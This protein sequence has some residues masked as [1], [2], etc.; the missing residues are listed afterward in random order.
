MSYKPTFEITP[1]LVRLIIE[2]TELRIWIHESVI[3]VPWLPTLQRETAIRLTHSS[4]AIEGNPL[5]L[6][7][8]QMVIE[9]KEIP[10]SQKAKLEVLNQYEA[11]KWVSK[12][13]PNEAITE[14]SLLTLHRIIT[15][16][17]LP[18]ELS[19]HFKT[20]SNRIVDS[21]GRTVYTPPPP[22]KARPMTL[23]LLA[24][25]NSDESRKLHPTISSAI[26]HYQHVSIHPFADGNGRTSRALAIWILYTRGFDTDHICALDEY[27]LKEHQLYYDK[28]TQAREL[29][30]DLTYWLEYV[31]KGVVQ[32]LKDTK[33]RILSLQVA[34]KGPKI[35]L[36]KRQEDVL[37]LLRDKGR[38][39]SPDIEDALK[40][41]RARVAQIMQPL[42]KMG[43]VIREGQTR[44]TTY[45]LG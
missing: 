42:V 36:T 14:S 44:A 4:T 2:A 27:F 38:L 19:G 18:D 32:A 40:L 45:R 1:E 34:H 12:R 33:E 28:L 35:S 7:E 20:R 43:L 24:W 26:A 15:K 9:G 25:L 5:S 3:D 13:K 23:D 10:T 41:T 37:R 21:Q 8:V 29:D 31:A 22:E 39:K 16:K 11:L 17:L 30:H 6:F